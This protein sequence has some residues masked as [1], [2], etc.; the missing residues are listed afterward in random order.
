MGS[1]TGLRTTGQVGDDASNDDIHRGFTRVYDYLDRE[2]TAQ[3]KACMVFDPIMVEHLLCKYQRVRTH[4]KNA[5]NRGQK[6]K[7]KARGS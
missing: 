3:E 5:Q 4:L 2:L 7:G 6:S 1:L